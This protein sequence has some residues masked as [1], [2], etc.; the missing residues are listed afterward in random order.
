MSALNKRSFLK[1]LGLAFGGLA[2][3]SIFKPKSNPSNVEKTA[4]LIYRIEFPKPL[5]EAEF[6]VV[7]NQFF[8]RD[9]NK[10]I[11]NEIN[12]TG[13]LKRVI[14][15]TETSYQKTLT[16]PSHTDLQLYLK[17]VGNRTEVV[18]H[19]ILLDSGFKA[20]FKVVS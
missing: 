7:A 12:C 15:R 20:Y 16:F 13:R 2:T 1:F 8:N 18:N 10:K 19:N 4:T 3:G 5:T 9:L 17:A 11:I 6:K 14:V